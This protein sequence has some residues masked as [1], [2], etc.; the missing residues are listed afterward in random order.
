MQI[1][2][3]RLISNEK[4][5]ELGNRPISV[6]INGKRTEPVSIRFLPADVDHFSELAQQSKHLLNDVSL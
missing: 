6:E 1:N 3:L 5:S 2:E 4:L